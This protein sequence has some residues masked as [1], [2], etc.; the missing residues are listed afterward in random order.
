[1]IDCCLKHLHKLVKTG[2]QKGRF[3]L[4]FYVIEVK[5]D[6]NCCEMGGGE[7]GNIDGAFMLK[8]WP[9]KQILGYS[10]YI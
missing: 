10:G 5:I 8:Q 7:G 6:L 4:F 2:P 3:L 1:M 9:E